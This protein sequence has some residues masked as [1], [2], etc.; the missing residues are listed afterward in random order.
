MRRGRA[1]QKIYGRGRQKARPD[2][3]SHGELARRPGA[4]RRLVTFLARPRKVTKGRP[5]QGVPPPCPGVPLCCLTRQGGCGTR[6]GKA[7][8]TCLAMGLE[9]SS[10]TPPCRVELLGAPHGGKG[11]CSTAYGFCSVLNPDFCAFAPL[12]VQQTRRQIE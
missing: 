4:A 8:K 5:P 10:P 2:P 6:P 1:I 11:K 9:Q 12:V 7:H 3:K